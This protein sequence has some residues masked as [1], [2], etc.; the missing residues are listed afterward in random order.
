MAHFSLPI[1][2]AHSW[3]D[4]VAAWGAVA[5]VLLGASEPWGPDPGAE[6]LALETAPRRDFTAGL[7]RPGAQLTVCAEEC[8]QGAHP[9]GGSGYYDLRVRLVVE[10][11]T[12]EVTMTSAKV[13]VSR[14]LG[15][16][17]LSF[18]G[19]M[20]GAELDAIVTTLYER[21]DER[22]NPT[23]QPRI[24][25]RN[26]EAV[27]EQDPALARRWLSMLFEH[28]PF[29]ASSGTRRLFE[30]H[31]ALIGPSPEM[32]A[33]RLRSQPADTDAWLAARAQPPRASPES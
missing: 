30:L 12:G 18:E 9:G 13:E 11:P 16:H 2:Q 26:I 17:Q 3:P 25:A 15:E 10:A 21:L 8:E 23:V 19:P 20:N 1:S 29:E 32:L 31:D 14:Q 33:R 28:S 22:P 7:Q 6:P 5:D 4:L 27:C 24:W